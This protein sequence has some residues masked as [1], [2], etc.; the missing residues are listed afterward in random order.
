MKWLP[1]F[2]LMLPQEHV[3]LIF[4]QFAWTGQDHTQE[5]RGC[6]AS[7][8]SEF[9]GCGSLRRIN[10]F[11]VDFEATNRGIRFSARLFRSR[12]NDTRANNFVNLGCNYGDPHRSIALCLVPTLHGYARY[13]AETI[14]LMPSYQTLNHGPVPFHIRKTISKTESDLLTMQI[15]H[16][17]AIRIDNRTTW[18]TVGEGPPISVSEKAVQYWDA[19]SNAFH[20][21][22]GKDGFQGLIQISLFLKSSGKNRLE[23]DYFGFFIALGLKADENAVEPGT[24]PRALTPWATLCHGWDERS[25]VLRASDDRWSQGESGHIM[26]NNDFRTPLPTVCKMDRKD[27][28]EGF[29]WN[30]DSFTCS[31]STNVD[32]KRESGIYELVFCIED[33]VSYISET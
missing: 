33:S 19:A 12:E 13:S 3:V 5:Y 17:F 21:L 18:L 30:K 32:T 9:Q 31:V 14:V 15:S 6:L 11:F 8:V 16:R 20:T 10:N 23:R 4:T 29:Y 2:T 22:L 28:A 7:S 25:L 24:E 27:F 26:F 1:I